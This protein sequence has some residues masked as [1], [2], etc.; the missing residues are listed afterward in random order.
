[1]V[2]IRLK[3]PYTQSEREGEE[4]E[5]DDFSSILQSLCWDDFG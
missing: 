3:F 5:K 4:Q 1:M 2:F